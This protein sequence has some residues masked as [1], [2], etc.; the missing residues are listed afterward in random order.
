[1]N[2]FLEHLEAYHGDS[3]LRFILLRSLQP[4]SVSTISST[5]DFSQFS[6]M[7]PSANML[8]P[9]S[10]SYA[11]PPYTFEPASPTWGYHDYSMDSE[12]LKV[13]PAWAAQTHSHLP[14]SQT[15][16]YNH[17]GISYLPAPIHSPSSPL[18]TIFPPATYKHIPVLMPKPLASQYSTNRPLHRMEERDETSAAMNTERTPSPL[19]SDEAVNSPCS[20][21]FSRSPSVLTSPSPSPRR[22]DISLP[23]SPAPIR[24]TRRLTRS[25]RTNIAPYFTLT[26]AKVK[27][28][29]ATASSKPRKLTITSDISSMAPRK[30]T[31]RSGQKD[32]HLA[33]ARVGLAHHVFRGPNAGKAGLATEDA[34]KNAK[35]KRDEF[36]GASCQNDVESGNE[37]MSRRGKV[38]LEVVCCQPGCIKVYSNPNGLRYHQ[39]KGGCE[40]DVEKLLKDLRRR[41]GVEEAD[42]NV[43]AK[44]EED[45]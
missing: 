9:S 32:L 6:T 45:D 42:A 4:G 40:I 7:T 29:S 24:S 36:F 11:C 19:R 23:N 16:E 27:I 22:T 43:D 39:T 8:A 10:W 31:R 34:I 3:H 41:D 21:C 38:E 28:S 15:L 17:C 5:S 18:V 33:L 30:K 12:A 1:M 14:S 25:A 2:A 13:S 37:G 20:P 26:K 44:E 35:R